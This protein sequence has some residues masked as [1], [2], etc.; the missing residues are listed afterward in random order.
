[1]SLQKHV[2]S[3]GRKPSST[4]RHDL[5]QRRHRLTVRMASFEQ[6]VL[7]FMALDDETAWSTA[8]AK[9]REDSEDEAYADES[10]DEEMGE[11]AIHPESQM[12][13]LPSSLAPGEIDRLGLTGIAE[14]EGKL[15]RG[16]I[17]D[18][19]EGLRLALGEKSLLFRTQVRKSRSQRTM[20]RAWKD[21]NKQDAVAQGHKRAYD[22]ARK[23][24]KTLNVDR[25]Y[26]EG[27]K[28]I[29]R[30]DMKMA[31]DVTEENRVG[32][33]SSTLAWF[34]R[35][36]GELATDETDINPRLKECESFVVSLMER[37]LINM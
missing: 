17:N 35:L 15:R 7:A 21:V 1:M 36:G 5:L 18:A 23:A 19:L 6:K 8:N 12:L 14:Q 16:Q 24:L 9:V 31:G 20:T 27:L 34:W 13:S 11:V 4:Q 26:V 2:K 29:T 25:E 32:Q 10:D 22:H 33:R 30:D 37:R 3:L 28:E